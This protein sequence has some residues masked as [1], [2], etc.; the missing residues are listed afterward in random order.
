VASAA[1][2]GLISFMADGVLLDWEGVLA[3]TADARRDAL[4]VAFSDEG[5][6][7]DQTAF[8]NH[9]AGRSVRSA[10]ARLLGSRAADATLV[11]L[12]A[13]RA[14]REFAARIAQGF[15]IDPAAARFT[16]QSQLRAPVVIVTAAGRAESEAALRLAGLHDSCA[17]IVTADDVGGD[18]PAPASYELALAHLGRRRVVKA[19]RVV[20]LASSIPAIRSAREAGLRTIAVNAPAHVA[21]EADAAIGSLD[22]LTLDAVDSLLGIATRRSA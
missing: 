11:E 20:V 12:V 21:L 5:I 1:A 14:E 8:A 7:F 13:L 6:A 17:A 3:D 18:A 16:E 15:A 10:V 2:P 19:D 9:G 4:R 22:G